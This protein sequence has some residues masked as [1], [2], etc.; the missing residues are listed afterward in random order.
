MKGLVA[1]AYQLKLGKNQSNMLKGDKAITAL[2]DAMKK[3]SVK[4]AELIPFLDALMRRDAAPGL[5]QARQSSIAGENRFGNEKDRFWDNFQKG[6]GE[7][8][9][10]TFWDMMA[11]MMTWWADNGTTLGRYFESSIYYLDGFRLAIGEFWK[12]AT[13]GESTQITDWL[14]EQGIDMDGI[15]ESVIKVL[16]SLSNLFTEIGEMVG[17]N[18]DGSWMLGLKDKITTFSNNLIGIMESLSSMLDNIHLAISSFRQFKDLT[19][20]EQAG[21]FMPGQKS[22]KLVTDMILGT[23]GAVGDIV[24]GTWK[25]GTTAKD[26]LIGDKSSPG[27][28]IPS[29]REKLISQIPGMWSPTSPE[30]IAANN[31]REQIIWQKSEVDVKVNITGDEKAITALS[32]TTNFSRADFNTM[33]SKNIAR[34]LTAVP[35]Q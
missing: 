26:V 3:G 25:A 27:S 24:G 5:A 11:G 9:L 4:T 35:K 17:F 14:K 32:N 22:N 6:G 13:T 8:G 34:E 10:K 21:M 12:F 18:K 15:R 16:T 19:L 29:E 20:M 30:G 23:G 7:K 2:T 1:E 28:Y 31:K 33:L